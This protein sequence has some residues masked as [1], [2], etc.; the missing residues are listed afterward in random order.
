MT[1]PAQ[2]SDTS[3]S[4][5]HLS[6]ESVAAL[7]D[8]ELSR[9]AEHRA[10]VHL[11]HCHECREEVHRQR[12][13]SEYVRSH[14]ADVHPSG[15]LVARLARIPLEV[16]AQQLEQCGDGRRSG[17]GDRFGVDGRRRPE[18]LIDAVDLLVRKLHKKNN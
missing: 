10:K 6:L 1:I 11:V 5:E 18:T 16:A 12:Q 15:D 7:V 13:A 14:E 2:D 4:V 8:G 17:A 3:L 9:R